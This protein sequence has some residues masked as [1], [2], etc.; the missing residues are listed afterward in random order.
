M[1]PDPAASSLYSRAAAPLGL[2]DLGSTLTCSRIGL[3]M[4]PIRLRLHHASLPPSLRCFISSLL[5]SRCESETLVGAV[6]SEAAAALTL[7][8]PP[9]S[10]P[11]GPYSPWAISLL[12]S[13]PPPL[14]CP[15]LHFIFP[16]LL[17]GGSS[18][19]SP[20]D[21]FIQQIS[22]ENLLCA[23]HHSRCCQYN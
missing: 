17:P 23:Q 7:P 11:H 13:H 12:R 2:W 21:L 19:I 16:G 20:V 14:H 4:R 8:P 15:R 9:G 3:F 5:F 1:T 22:I 10:P 6:S 18:E